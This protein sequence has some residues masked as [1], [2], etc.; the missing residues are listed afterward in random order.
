MNSGTVYLL[1]RSPTKALVN[2]T[3]EEAWTGI[4]LNV[5]NLKIF[6]CIAYA[7]VPDEKRTKMESKSIKCIFIGYFGE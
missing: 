7:H 3:P 5:S 1:N 4:K 6:G 2:K